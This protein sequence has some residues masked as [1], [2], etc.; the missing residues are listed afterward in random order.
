MQPGRWFAVRFAL[1]AATLLG[2]YY[3]PYPP[4]SAVKHWLDA[5]LAGY[6]ATAGFVLRRFEP[7]VYVVG[8][9]I[10]GRYS[11]RIVKTCDAM[12]VKI[13]LVSAI[14]A[15]PAPAVRRVAAALVAVLA[16]FV[17]NVTR[18]CTLYYVGLTWPAAFEL[19][20]LE[21]WPALILVVAV[22][23]FVGYIAWT[24]RARRDELA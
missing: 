21:I 2:L 20:H 24:S 11:L 13:L 10:L 23:A 15:W 4:G 1:L 12:D 3:F 16:L 18:I 8:Q 9:D 19:L 6:A 22:A 14:V 17:V 5:Y 7:A